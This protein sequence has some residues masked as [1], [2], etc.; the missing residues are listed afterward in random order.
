MSCTVSACEPSSV[1]WSSEEFCGQKC[2]KTF[3]PLVQQCTDDK[4]VNSTYNQTCN[5]T[6]CNLTEG[7]QN[8]STKKTCYCEDDEC[9]K[10]CSDIKCTQTCRGRENGTQPLSSLPLISA[11]P[12][13][14]SRSPSPSSSSSQ[15]IPTATPSMTSRTIS[16]L[17]KEYRSKLE[18]INLNEKASLQKAMRIFEHFGT[19]IESITELPDG[20]SDVDEVGE[21][22]E[23][24]FKVVV[25]LEE[26]A[27][28][29]GKHHL[30]GTKQSK[31][32]DSQ[33][34]VLMITKASR[35]NASG[36]N[37]Q[38]E[39]WKQS[40]NISSANFADYGKV[41]VGFMYK[42]LHQLL[43]LKHPIKERT[44]ITRDVGSRIMA[45]AMDPKPDMRENVILKFRNVE[46]VEGRKVCAFWSGFRER[47]A[48]DGFSE[49][50]CHL[51]TSERN[52]EETICSCNHLTHF[53]VLVD[54]NSDLK[55]TEED[56]TILEIITYVGLS[57][58]II[59][60]LLTIILYSFLT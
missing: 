55:L 27:L 11:T 5:A 51:V 25:I 37:L 16:K 49:E 19:S 3:S 60:I 43:Q 12:N 33:K 38:K 23:S 14:P 52:S 17:A 18:R 35:Q 45:V 44:G 34:M 4:H 28:N 20:Q 56:E 53:A 26:I 40:I 47:S 39:E 13:T 30:I 21:R 9:S 10:T 15:S 32:I 58:S 31:R 48:S 54:Y 36:F 1:H 41:V 6:K 29:Y 59:G 42:D 22:R 24:I 50:G 2:A 7:E 57:L 8:F 46:E